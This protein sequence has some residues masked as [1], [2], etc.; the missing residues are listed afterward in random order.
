MGTSSLTFIT[1]AA[2]AL[3]VLPDGDRARAFKSIIL[4]IFNSLL[5]IASLSSIVPILVLLIKGHLTIFSLH[6]KVTEKNLTAILATLILFFLIKNAIS[7]IIL[8]QQYDF[9][10]KVSNDLSERLFNSFFQRD[11][12][13]YAK[14]NSSDTWRKISNISEEFAQYVLMGYLNVLTE[15]MIT[16]PVLLILVI[17][18]KTVFLI[19]VVF[20]LPA[21]LAH[22]FIKRKVV[23]RIDASFKEKAPVAASLLYQGIDSFTE[24]KVYGSEQY[25]IRRYIAVRR[26]IIQDLNNFKIAT[27]LPAKIFEIVGVLCFSGIIMY[28]DLASSLNDDLILLLGILAA[29]VYRIIPSL[30]KILVTISQI[31]AYLYTIDEMNGFETTR[32]DDKHA[33]PFLHAIKIASVSFGYVPSV[34]LFSDLTVSIRKGDFVLLQGRSGTGKTSLL[35]IL[36]GMITT[37]R[38]A[39]I[40]D[41]TPLSTE[42][43]RAWQKNLGIVPQQPVILDESLLKNIIF[44]Q[45]DSD[46]N[47]DFLD[48]AVR[49][50]GLEIFIQSLSAGLDT[51]LGDRGHQISG[52]QAQRIALARALYKNPTVLLLDEFTNQLDNNTKEEILTNLKNHNFTIIV[53][54]HDPA[55]AKYADNVIQ[56]G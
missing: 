44:D 12:L 37:Y 24:A 10:G 14:Q 15:A 41:Q 4:S 46:I 51:K 23:D 32:R 39:L 17:Y 13:T 18:N 19:C 5:E 56:L 49:L 31:Q 52:G 30:N 16:L 20:G 2:K 40:I 50:S 54:S 53:S 28:A 9:V 21:L 11:W 29:G 8:K 36:A 47:K 38:G 55:L 48:N 6:I 33:L 27:S 26:Q 43:I 1:A 35:N 34:V 25:F 7:M 42:L 22:I 45:D 3:R